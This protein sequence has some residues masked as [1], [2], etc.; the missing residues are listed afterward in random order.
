MK[1]KDKFAEICSYQSF[2]FI[3]WFGD[4]KYE[5]KVSDLYSKRLERYMSDSE[6]LSEL[7]PTELTL[8]EVFNYLEN[9]ANKDCS[10][11]FYCRDKN[12]ELRAVGVYWDDGGW[13]VYA[14]SVEGP[15]RWAGGFRVFSRNPFDTNS[16]VS[17]TIS[18]DETLLQT[19]TRFI[20]KSPQTQQYNVMETEDVLVIKRK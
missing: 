17:Q 12:G 20:S 9:K 11:I 16:T 5:Q 6:I 8:G 15:S 2:Y 1:I 3:E 7:K 18:K 10:M 13:G 19:F 4:M 14:L